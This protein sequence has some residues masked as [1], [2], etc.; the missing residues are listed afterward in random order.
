MNGQCRCTVAHTPRRVVITGGPG[1]GKTAVLEMVRRTFCDHVTVLPEA[2]GIIYGGGFPRS[3]DATARRAAQRCIY[4]VQVELEQ[5]ASGP[6]AA[7]D[8]CD[9][10]T[11]DGLAYWPGSPAE[12]WRDMGSSLERELARY[13]GVIHLRTPAH[14]AY[15]HRNPLRVETAAEAAAIDDRILSVWG[16][17]PRRQVIDSSA[18]FLDKVAHTLDAIRTW[19]PPCCA[20]ASDGAT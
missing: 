5:L 1:A 8:L 20:T 9:R 14:E 11:I 6:S 19:V 12:F 13:A 15:N 3:K 16:A 2:A 10:G 17:H 18:H 4:R 7:L